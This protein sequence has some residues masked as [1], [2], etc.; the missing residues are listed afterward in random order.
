MPGL[1]FGSVRYVPPE[2]ARDGTATAESDL[3]SLGATLY[4]AVEGRSPYART[5]AMATLT[6]LATA[7]PDPPRRAGPLKPVLAGLL[8]RNPRDRLRPEDV[9]RMLQRVAAAD[10]VR[11]RRPRRNKRQEAVDTGPSLSPSPGS[12]RSPYPIPADGVLFVDPVVA[13]EPGLSAQPTVPVDPANGPTTVLEPGRRRAD[14][15]VFPLRRAL[16]PRG[17]RWLIAGLAGA[18]VLAV[19]G[20]LAAAAVDGRR[21]HPGAAGQASR[22]PSSAPAVTVVQPDPVLQDD[23]CPT[24][25]P[26]EFTP[27]TPQPGWYALL[28]GW[29]WYRDPAGYRIAAPAGWQVYRGLN[30]LCFREPDGARVL[31]VMTW[32]S[33][34]SPLAHLTDRARQVV[35]DVR[36]DQYR[37]LRIASAPLYYT[38]AADWEFEFVNGAGV[39]MH[40]DARG[41]LVAP[42]K[43]YTIVWCTQGFDWSVN[44][45]YFRMILASFG[46]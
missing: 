35:D 8:R 46:S 5:S 32:T 7:L 36:P 20:A 12:L 23:A 44:Q 27:T 31:G 1:V 38:S 18:L 4:A 45:D 43:G 17:R 40:A 14:D 39:P 10:A 13:M 15:P 22:P 41:F 29:V 25:D 24:T 9:R 16:A 28:P 19:S 26:Q 33:T 34:D 3:W 30:G 2:R 21:G 11:P 42:G 37:Q 6:A